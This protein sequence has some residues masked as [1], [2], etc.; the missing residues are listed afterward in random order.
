MTVVRA[1]DQWSVDLYK[2]RCNS[3]TMHGHEKTPKTFQIQSNG[4]VTLKLE[5]KLNWKLGN[6][7]TSIHLHTEV[8]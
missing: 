6:F 7:D 5:V 2:P 4:V 3:L 1:E 8:P